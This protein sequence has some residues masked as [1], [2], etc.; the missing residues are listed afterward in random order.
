VNSGLAP[1]FVHC[2]LLTLVEA[3]PRQCG[4]IVSIIETGIVS[5]SEIISRAARS[6]VSVDAGIQQSIDSLDH[7]L[8]TLRGLTD[9]GHIDARTLRDIPRWHFAMLNDLERNDAFAVALERVVPANA[10]VLDIGSGTGLLA[11][12]AVRAGAGHVTTC[13]ANP[14][15]ARIAERVIEVNGLAD[16]ITVVPRMS[17]DLVVGRDLPARADLVVS[18]IVDCGLIGEGILPT[19]RH[20]RRELLVDGGRML[21]EG[22]RLRGALVDSRVVAGLNHVGQAGGFDVRPFN[23]VATQGH[24]PVRL[25]TWPHRM[26]TAPTELAALDLT[27]EAPEESTVRVTLP[28]RSPGTAHALVA[29]FEMDLGAGVTLS[30][31]P[32]NVGS[33]WMQA[34]I[35]LPLPAPVFAGDHVELEITWQA[36]LLYARPLTGLRREETSS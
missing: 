7:A 32:D 20:A 12:M 25:E 18:E 22:A 33:H 2:T 30:N 16:R 11:M 9:P 21:P 19:V 17:T 27:G 31:S 29:W 36:G 1:L 5:P 34:C 13:E 24:F 14:V 4:E 3:V 23:V 26:L 8:H 6:A 28:V 10:H 15:L 35:P